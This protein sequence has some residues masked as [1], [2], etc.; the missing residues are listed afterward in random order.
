MEQI[1]EELLIYQSRRDLRAQTACEHVTP[2]T[3]LKERIKKFC[4]IF[5]SKSIIC[6]VHGPK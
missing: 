1:E 6:I 4:V 5:K 3:A 2:V